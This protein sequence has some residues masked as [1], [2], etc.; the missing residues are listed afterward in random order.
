[1]KKSS[2]AIRPS[3][4][5][6]FFASIY[7][8]DMVE[9]TMIYSCLNR[10]GFSPV[11]PIGPGVP[12]ATMER[13]FFLHGLLRHLTA[14]AWIALLMLSSAQAALVT[15]GVPT[16]ISGDG[17]V[18]RSGALERA[19]HLGDANVGETKVNGV[20]FAPFAVTPAWQT[21]GKDPVTVGQTTLTP[22]A[23]TTYFGYPDFGSA[24]PPFSALPGATQALLWQGC[25]AVGASPRF[26]LTLSN[27]VVG[28]TY[29][30]QIWANDSQDVKGEE[31]DTR[32]TD[33]TNEVTLHANATGQYDGGVGQWVIG[34]FTADATEQ[35]FVF[36]QP[37]SNS[38]TLNAFQ[39]RD[40][41]GVSSVTWGV[42]TTISGDGDVST[43]GALERAYHF[44]DANVGEIMVHG[45]TFAPFAVTPAWQT[46]GKDPVTVGQTTLT[47]GA[48][49]TCFGYPGFGSPLP[50]FSALSAAYQVLFWQ[51]CFA[52]GASPRFTLTLNNL[53]VGN[54]Y[55]IQIWASD[56]QDV[57]GEVRD[58]RVS[59]GAN[60][61]TLHANATGQT[62]G[63]VG[64]WVI[65]TFT[66]NK[67]SQEFGFD[68][69]AAN[70]L[71]LNAFQLRDVTGFSTVTWDMPTTTITGNSKRVVTR[72]T[73]V[74]WGVPP[75]VREDSDASTTP[76]KQP[77]PEL[78][79]IPPPWRNGQC[80]REMIMQEGKW[81]ATRE[82]IR[83]IGA[84][85]WLMN[86]YFSD[87]EIRQ[88]FARLR[89][90][91]KGFGFEVPV[92]KAP[93]WGYPYPL[94]AKEAF[95]R[96]QQFAKR[97][98][99]LG[100]DQVDWFAFD[101]PIFHAREMIP[102]SSVPHAPVKLE[103]F[104]AVKNDPEV[105]RRIAHGVSET[106]SYIAMMRPAFPGA[107]LGL[108]EP[109]P[110]LSF[111][112]L[113]TAVVGIQSECARQGIKGLDFFRLDLDWV[114][115]ER[116][117]RPWVEVRHLENMCRANGVRFSNIFWNASSPGLEK[118]GLE[119]PDS[120]TD[121]IL[122]FAR[123]YRQVGGN[124][125]EIVI[126]SW[127]RTPERAVPETD[128]ETFTA[129]VLDFVRLYP[130]A[131]WIEDPKHP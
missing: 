57:G 92:L 55:Q 63:G 123:K 87:D 102:A 93:N 76:L 31:R 30:I 131:S 129:S 53:V 120:W 9:N 8:T 51:G 122:H 34:T 107:R 4:D 46:P 59:D 61:V 67:T 26:T 20:T 105:A 69:P 106:V 103:L 66:A 109:Y 81:E 119:T 65:G 130:P 12:K 6:M 121:G 101:E 50:P 94:Q 47:P 74:S 84:Y 29:Q 38:L 64:Q 72:R 95:D 35:E 56:S 97:F 18:S 42:P 118:A 124:P 98:K 108:I 13:N 45:V 40:I 112:E 115:L 14:M 58:T 125:D 1:M 15:W 48:G 126:E 28:K 52:V 3:W 21:P 114:R 128:P 116:E 41:T 111:D 2:H 100:M 5:Q 19:Y 68:Q 54:T 62:G 82:Q 11:C 43:S 25:F 60:E 27:L 17:D 89:A 16:T 71:T 32:V 117:K 99:S 79:I 86:E 85:A 23:G 36:D 49:T 70:A 22:G 127:L 44:G 33:G 77:A 110:A 91:N 88:L 113:K 80:L 73:T 75:V 7:E 90:W 39:L 96:L 37:V 24:L 104:G 78:W 10:N 83:G